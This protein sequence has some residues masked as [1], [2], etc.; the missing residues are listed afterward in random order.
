MPWM[1]VRDIKTNKKD[2]GVCMLTGSPEN[3]PAQYSRQQSTS[4]TTKNNTDI[5]DISVYFE[6]LGIT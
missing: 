5:I 6:D 3:V 4:A 1:S 2:A